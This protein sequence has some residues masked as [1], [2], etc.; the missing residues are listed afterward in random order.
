[1]MP[2]G[3]AGA[4]YLLYSLTTRLGYRRAPTGIET[5][6]LGFGTQFPDIVDKPLAAIGVLS[7]GR[8][9]AHSLLTLTLLFGCLFVVLRGSQYVSYLVPFV[10]GCLSHVFTDIGGALLRGQHFGTTFLVWPFSFETPA[11]S[12]P[13]VFQNQYVLYVLGN[14]DAQWG[15]ALV[16]CLLWLVESAPHSLQQL[17]PATEKRR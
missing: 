7:Y 17:R 3:H 12:V 13:L 14:H 5:V 16:A 6:V 11:Y 8:S 10:V 9:L 15:L 1:M 2:W 4:G